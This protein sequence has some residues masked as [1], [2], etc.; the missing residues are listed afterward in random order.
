MTGPDG[1]LPANLP[2]SR[3]SEISRATLD[4][5]PDAKKI[6]ALAADFEATFV[7]MLLK[8]M[9]QTLD[10]DGGF[11]AGDTGDVQGGL[12][13]MYLSRHLS[14]AGGIGMAKAIEQQLTQQTTHANVP[15]TPSPGR[16]TSRPPAA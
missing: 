9:R 13:D 8:E 16:A 4:R 7:S 6:K 3:P 5:S 12:F 1:I 15:G 11:F 10:E 14:E 2:I